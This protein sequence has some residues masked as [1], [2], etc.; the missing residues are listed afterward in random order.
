MHKTETVLVCCAWEI[1]IGCDG[2]KRWSQSRNRVSQECKMVS[3]SSNPVKQRCVTLSSPRAHILQEFKY[4]NWMHF[5]YPHIALS[6]Y[7]KDPWDHLGTIY[8]VIW[9]WSVSHYASLSSS[10]C[11]AF[12]SGKQY[13]SFQPFRRPYLDSLCVFEQLR[14]L[15]MND[16]CIALIQVSSLFDYSRK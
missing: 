5:P 6:L 11:W 3:L 14:P 13:F 7:F 9:L 15:N 8:C 1:K 2:C 10:Y 4:L 12:S 16:A